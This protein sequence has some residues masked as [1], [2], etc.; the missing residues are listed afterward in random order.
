MSLRWS[1]SNTRPLLTA[2]PDIE[3]GRRGAQPVARVRATGRHHAAAPADGGGGGAV[4]QA[5]A[6]LPLAKASSA[7]RCRLM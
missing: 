5:A 2:Q 3:A 6:A 7:F 4:R 1:T